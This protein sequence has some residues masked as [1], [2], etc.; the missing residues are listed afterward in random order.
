MREYMRQSSNESLTRADTERLM[1]RGT[2]LAMDAAGELDASGQAIPTT[3][4][5]AAFNAYEAAVR[6][7]KD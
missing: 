1:Q 4:E 2:R 5:I 6:G 3:P 7:L